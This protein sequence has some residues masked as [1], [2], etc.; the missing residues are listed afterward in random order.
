M[1]LVFV[2]IFFGLI[3]ALFAA[4]CAFTF[5]S[6]EFFFE[7][8]WTQLLKTIFTQ[9]AGI[10]VAVVWLFSSSKKPNYRFDHKTGRP[11]LISEGWGLSQKFGVC[12]A[13]FWFGFISFVIVSLFR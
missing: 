12:M 2:I 13:L 3:M 10:L 1:E 9:I 7:T 11:K 4:L 8:S 6:F 5:K